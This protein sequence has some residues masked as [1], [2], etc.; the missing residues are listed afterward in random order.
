MYEECVRESR[1]PGN[2]KFADEQYGN[3]KKAIEELCN[4]EKNYAR[5]CLF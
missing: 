4:L 1:I 5:R 2:V 3:V